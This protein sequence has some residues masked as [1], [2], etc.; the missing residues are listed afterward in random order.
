MQNSAFILL[1]LLALGKYSVQQSWKNDKI[2]RQW[3]PNT[4][5]YETVQNQAQLN[6][7]F[8]HPAGKN[9]APIPLQ[10]V[11]QAGQGAQANGP[12]PIK[13]ETMTNTGEKIVENLIGGIPFDC[14]TK[15]TGHW[16]DGNF[17]DIFH[18]CVY[19]QQRKSYVCPIVGERTYFDEVTK[20]CEFLN[21]NPTACSVNQFYL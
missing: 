8:L 1:S 21:Q 17:C 7:E 13:Q 15:P 6:E 19:G 3:E 12:Y 16:R 4:F 2:V 10:M 18:A 11:N 9:P 14:A 5:Q 20:R